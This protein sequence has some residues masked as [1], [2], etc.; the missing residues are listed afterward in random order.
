LIVHSTPSASAG[1]RSTTASI[2]PFHSGSRATSV[3]TSK[4][5]CGAASIR[6]EARP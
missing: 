2:A 4:T 1:G 6:T 5:A 3:I